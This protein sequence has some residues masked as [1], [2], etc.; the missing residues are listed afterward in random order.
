[1][2]ATPN[3]P[4]ARRRKAP[5]P[6]RVVAARSARTTR[7][8]WGIC[9]LLWLACLHAL[10]QTDPRGP[11]N[12]EFAGK[13]RKTYDDAKARLQA[14]TNNSEA[15]WQFARACFD[16]ADYAK[17]N[18]ERAEVAEEGIAISRLLL[19]IA[20]NSVPGHYYLG[21]NLGQLARTK[22]L[23]ALKIVTQMENEFEQARDLDP[24]FDYAGPDRNLA[25]LYLDAPS[26]PVSVGSK[27]KARQHFQRAL[28]LSPDY[29][30]NRLN[31][32]EAELKW[33]EKKDAAAGLE[34]L[35]QLWPEAR[36]KLAG[37]DWAASWAEWEARRTAAREESASNSK[38]KGPAGK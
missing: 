3:S 22:S 17:N 38:S 24:N 5:A 27:I 30:G 21:M 12:A 25:M 32:I 4:G 9:L 6:Q 33:D 26:W 19:K 34:A 28:K 35:D 7:C 29:P 23:G 36:K 8:C 13:T 10:A 2:L 18:V 11:G 31:L 15:M 14:D 1:M 16:R 37:D 20:T